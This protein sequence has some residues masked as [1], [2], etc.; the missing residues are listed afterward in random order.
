[1]CGWKFVG[2]LESGFP[3]I[4]TSI[5]L[6]SKAQW[7]PW[8]WGHWGFRCMVS[9]FVW[10]AQNVKNKKTC[11]G[12]LPNVQRCAVVIIHHGTSIF[13]SWVKLVQITNMILNFV[14]QSWFSPL[15][16]L[17]SK[18]LLL[19]VETPNVCGERPSSV[20]KTSSSAQ[21]S[22]ASIE[23]SMHD[24][25]I[26]AVFILHTHKFLLPMGWEHRHPILGTFG[27]LKI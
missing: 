1:M 23:L 14:C 9:V 22:W 19:K 8:L 3:C 20:F 18:R 15:P 10:K 7:S 11:S 12:V 16:I 21:G 5:W 17:E 6:I 2:K 27:Y 4:H 26:H 25:D 24:M 13:Q